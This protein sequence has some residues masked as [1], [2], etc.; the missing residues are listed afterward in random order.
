MTPRWEMR[1]PDSL[2]KVGWGPQQPWGGSSTGKYGKAHS[3]YFSVPSG[4]SQSEFPLFCY[5]E[6]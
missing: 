2:A 6:L 1:Q 3:V 5:R 4:Y